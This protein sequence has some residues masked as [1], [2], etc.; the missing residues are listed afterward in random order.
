M[1]QKLLC[2]TT[3]QLLELVGKKIT[4]DQ[5]LQEQEELEEAKRKEAIRQEYPTCFSKDHN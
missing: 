1:Y 2:R 5:L 4:E 3:G